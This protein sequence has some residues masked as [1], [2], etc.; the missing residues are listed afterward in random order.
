MGHNNR[1]KQGISVIKEERKL[2]M[3]RI[4]KASMSAA[5]SVF[6]FYCPCSGYCSSCDCVVGYNAASAYRGS[7]AQNNPHEATFI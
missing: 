3:K 7:L 1:Y 6:S 5:Q 2:L 4:H